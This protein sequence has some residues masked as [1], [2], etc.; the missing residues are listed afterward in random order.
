MS[1]QYD[2]TVGPSDTI[3]PTREQILERALD[4]IRAMA[5][6][7]R[8]GETLTIRRG[9]DGGPAIFN[10]TITA[11]QPSLEEGQ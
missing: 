3:L 9:P 10:V 4:D 11:E 5:G 1:D 7:L 8:P 2:F 6:R